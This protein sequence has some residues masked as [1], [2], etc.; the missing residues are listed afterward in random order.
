MGLLARVA[1]I[2]LGAYG[3]RAAL[4]TARTRPEA[5]QLERTNFRGRT[6]TLA[7]GPAL[8]VSA[9]LSSALGAGDARTATAALAAGLS[10]GAVGLYDDIVGA[11]PD[12]RG[13]K[14]FRGHLR[15]LR[16]GRVTSGLVKIAGVGA[17]AL[18]AAA[19]LPDRRGRGRLGRAVEVA[20]GAG[21]IA[22]SANL[23]NLLDLRPGRAL[24]AGLLVGAPLTATRAGGLAAGPVGA[25][26]GLLPDDL[27]EEIMLGDSGANALGALLGVAA[28]ARTGLLGRAALL[29][30]L[31][32]LTLASEKVSFT[33]V[34]ERTPVLREID[35]WGR[36]PAPKQQLPQSRTAADD[37]APQAGATTKPQ[38]GPAAGTPLA[39]LT[40]RAG[41]TQPQAAAPTTNQTSTPPQVAAP[42]TGPAV[43]SPP[44]A[45]SP[46]PGDGPSTPEVPV[47]GEQTATPR[48]AAARKAFRQAAEAGGG[49]GPGAAEV[50]HATDAEAAA[51]AGETAAKPQPR[52]RA[53]RRTQK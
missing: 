51:P 53:P 6:V 40:D 16:E 44:T 8:A 20:L 19:L 14:G 26:A 3:A 50:D 17:G 23:Y 42:V 31:G 36:L 25:S 38:P 52:A 35:A 10:G 9:S 49:H 11:R 43:D 22:G 29:T 30:G 27:G 45:S 13:D 21:V 18:A 2:G 24:K 34:I 32:A 46:T 7:G 1:L 37:P 41:G 15:A 48:R 4:R 47:A 39:A 28:T 5:A 33:K 12:Q